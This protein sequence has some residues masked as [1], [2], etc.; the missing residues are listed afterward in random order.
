MY[1]RHMIVMMN[2]LE[3]YFILFCFLSLRGESTSSRRLAL[4][5]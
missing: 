3:Y 1:V 5:Y 4:L 2:V